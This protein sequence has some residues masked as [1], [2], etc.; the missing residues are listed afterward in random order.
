[1][2]KK[3]IVISNFHEEMSISRSNM[4]FKYFLSRDF[5]T[6]TLYSSFSHSLKIF[7]RLENKKCIPISTIGYKSSLSL[8]RIF[9]YFI[10][11]FNV[12]RYL[13]KVKADVI[14]LNLPPNLLSLAVFL[15]RDKKT[16]II[17]D[18]L[19]LWPESYPANNFFKKIVFFFLGIIP[20]QIRKYAINNCNFCI[21]ES[22]LFFNQLELNNKTNS[23]IIYL[24]KD[25]NFYPLA[26]YVSKDL[27]I[28]YLGNIGKIYDFDSLFKIIKEVEKSRPVHLHII[29]LGPM[30]VWFFENLK[31]NKIKYTYHGATFDEKVKNEVLSSCWFGF[32]GY[33]KDTEVALSYKSI[34]YLSSGVP[35]LNS[36]KEDTFKIVNE[37]NIG[38]NFEVEKLDNLI[39]S[40]SIISK[41]DIIEMKRKAYL[42]FCDKFSGESYYEEMDSVVEHIYN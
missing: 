18:I 5:D 3:V 41:S 39:K 25:Q 21:T 32:N 34:D 22:E 31:I 30:S 16:K 7:R 20:K 23:K 10:F 9:S 4:A 35:L 37:N 26:T 33:K 36:A 15:S 42:V 11:A 19:D 28:V 14:Y 17:I 13:R 12:Y 38:F 27:S 24:K 8:K 6:R 40:L 2:K 29:G 1:M